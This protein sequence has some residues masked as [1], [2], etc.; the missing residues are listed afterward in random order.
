MNTIESTTTRTDTA[1]PTTAEPE[2]TSAESEPAK[3]PETL[4][5]PGKK[6]LDAERVAR[7]DAERKAR[8]ASER[9]GTLERAERI[10]SVAA[11]KDLTSEQAEFLSGETEDELAKSAERLLAAF[12]PANEVPRRPREHLRSG[13]VPGSEPEEKGA[14]AD[15][16]MRDGW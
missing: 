3:P 5:G 12:K 4:G 16:I 6:A 14:V 10:R 1:E 8:E 2:G 9:L 11:D 7:R 15:A 13:A